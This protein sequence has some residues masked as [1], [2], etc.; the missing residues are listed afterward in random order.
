MYV[1]ANLAYLGT[2]FLEYYKSSNFAMTIS[3]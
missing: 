2:Y 3:A 1:S